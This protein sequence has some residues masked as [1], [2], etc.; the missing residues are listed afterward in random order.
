[1]EAV[2]GF[3]DGGED[4]GV[5]GDDG[6]AALLPGGEVGADGVFLDHGGEGG[7]GVGRG[8]EEGG[9]GVV[10]VDADLVE[11]AE[12]GDAAEAREDAVAVDRGGGG[13]LEKLDGHAEAG[14]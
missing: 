12:G 5:A 6:D 9:D 10:I 7:G 14:A 4:A 2:D 3:L 1:M 8:A 11:L 13:E